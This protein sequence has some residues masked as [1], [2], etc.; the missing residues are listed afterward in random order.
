MTGLDLETFLLLLRADLSAWL[1]LGLASV[2]LAVLVWVCWGSRRALRK[3]LVLS[4]AAHLGIVLFGSTVPAVQ[5]AIRGESDESA[6][7]SHIRRIRVA[8][9]VEPSKPPEVGP[10]LTRD[11]APSSGSDSSAPPAPRLELPSGPLR[12]ADVTIPAPRPTI[13]ER[14]SPDPEPVLPPPIPVVTATPRPSRPL[15]DPPV[16]GPRAEPTTTP[17]PLVPKPA[18]PLPPNLAEVDRASSEPPPSPAESGGAR[19]AGRGAIEAALGTRDRTLRTDA[20]LRP[21]LTGD[22]IK[23]SARGENEDAGLVGL[24]PLGASAGSSGS[25]TTGPGTASPAGADASA[26]PVPPARPEAA[27]TGLLALDRVI[28]KPPAASGGD[29]GLAALEERPPAR[30]LAEIPRSLSAPAGPRPSRPGPAPGRQQGER[31]RRGAC[32]RLAGPPPGR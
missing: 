24:G 31:A 6:D 5:L 2:G 30:T 7:R 1:M 8:P 11:R 32:P 29:S 21:K 18:P 14:S 28:P 27:T 13:A 9:L 15:P 25:G 22:P 16:V 20:R 17:D 19:G 10:S 23:A 12:L 26:E 4:L 3:C